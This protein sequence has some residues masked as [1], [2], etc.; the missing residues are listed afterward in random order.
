[1][2]TPESMQKTNK[3]AKPTIGV[4]W[5][6]GTLRVRTISGRNGDFNIADLITAC[7]QFRIKDQ[8]LDQFE[9]GE[10]IGRFEIAE[11]K[12]AC[13]TLETGRSINEMRAILADY[14][15]DMEEDIPVDNSLEKVI[16]PD[17]IDEKDVLPQ[18]PSTDVASEATNDI[19]AI[20]DAESSS[21]QEEHD[22]LLTLFNNDEELVDSVLNGDTVTLDPSIASVMDGGVNG[23]VLFREQ[24]DYL[25]KNGW[26]FNV[27]TQTW[28]RN[29]EDQS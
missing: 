13:Y 21:K 11:L 8:F 26:S 10:Y 12:I 27:K 19:D 18:V 3:S 29:S 22:A 5:I 23:R 25:K 28:H 17:P 7:G 9:P 14:D 20:N 4:F 6:N 1:M 15:I 2:R 24:R 16:P